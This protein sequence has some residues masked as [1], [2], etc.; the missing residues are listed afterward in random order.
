VARGIN[1]A[2]LVCGAVILAL[3]L[4]ALAFWQFAP[5]QGKHPQNKA[6]AAACVAGDLE[7]VRGALAKGADPSSRDETGLTPLMQAARGDRPNMSKP[8]VTDHP[9]VVQLLLE[10]RVDPNAATDSGF[11]ALFW[12]ARYGHEKVAKVLIDHGANVNAR[13]KDGLTALKW[14]QTNQSA[15]PE[16]Y[17]RLIELLKKAGASE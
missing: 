7:A 9:D 13:D 14:A 17:N 11:V 12:A 10:K 6:L 4:A 3:L 5:P 2:E 15:S 1:R 8:A 16:V